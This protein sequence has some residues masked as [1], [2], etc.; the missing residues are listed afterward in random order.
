MVLIDLKGI[1]VII[2]L[3]VIIVIIIIVR[4]GITSTL[5]YRVC[6]SKISTRSNLLGCLHNTCSVSLHAGDG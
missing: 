4:K 1:L 3:L 6:E 2:L 5:I